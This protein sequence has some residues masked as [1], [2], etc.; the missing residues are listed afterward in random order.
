MKAQPVPVGTHGIIRYWAAAREAAGCAEEA[1]AA[2]TL[3]AAL[4][5]ARLG[6]DQRFADVVRR[7]SF[8]VDG[9]PVGARDHQLVVLSDAGVIEV[10]PPFAGG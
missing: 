1:Y 4:E 9:D 3:A 8:V 2:G 7:C 6:R 10:L 5:T